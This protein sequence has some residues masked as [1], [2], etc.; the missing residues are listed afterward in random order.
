M[1]VPSSFRVQTRV[2]VDGGE[3]STD[4]SPR[5][6]GRFVGR[7]RGA[8]RI[9]LSTRKYEPEPVHGTGEAL[10]VRARALQVSTLSQRFREDAA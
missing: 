3:N 5:V 4:G 1:V 9:R 6:R 8:R 2:H 10:R 7:A